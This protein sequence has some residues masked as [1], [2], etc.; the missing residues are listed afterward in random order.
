MRHKEYLFRFKQFSVSHA[1]S[2]MHV[3][4]DAVL[5]GA[6]AGIPPS[7]RLLDV[8]TGCGVIA[9][10]AAQ[11][12]VDLNILAIDVDIPSVDEATANFLKSPWSDRIHAESADFSQLSPEDKGT[13]DMI[14]S[15]PPYFDSGGDPDLSSRMRARHQATLSPVSLITHGKGL[16]SP[17]GRIA[18]IFPA[19]FETEIDKVIDD[20]GMCLHRKVYVAGRVGA[21]PKR[22]IIEAGA[23]PAISRVPF[24]P[25]R[26]EI[27]ESPGKYTPAYIDLCKDLYLKF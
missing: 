25:E 1:V 5:L 19:E 24:E 17:S 7:G 22:I 21:P 14:I 26:I 16:L 10:I 9:L 18:M 3:G 23:A 12:S 27:E 20:C 2:S 8:G 4:V 6:V 15:N 13:F 11:R